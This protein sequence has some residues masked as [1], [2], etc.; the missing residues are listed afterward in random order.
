MHRVVNATTAGS[1][2]DLG[3]IAR[4]L[5]DDGINIAAVG[6]GEGSARGGSVGHIAFLT[7]ARAINVT[8]EHVPFQ[9]AANVATALLGRQ[10]DMATTTVAESRQFMSGGSD[11]R[12]RNRSM[13]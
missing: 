2:G 8:A 12:V 7:L 11:W 10:I 5:A 9:G 3:R 6:G 13:M 4:R 1:V